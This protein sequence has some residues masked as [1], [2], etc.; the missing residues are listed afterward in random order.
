VQCQLCGFIFNQQYEQ[1]SYQV[2]YESGRSS[3]STFKTYLMQ[4]ANLLLD[5]IPDKIGT[6]V[7]V[8]AGD[9]DFARAVKSLS[10]SPQYFA[11]DPSAN[12]GPQFTG[13]TIYQKYYDDSE[14]LFPDLVI[15]RHVLE[16]QSNVHQFMQSVLHES[17][18][19]CF[20]EIPCCSF[21][22]EENFHYFSYEH[23]SYFD[24]KSLMK[25]MSAFH[26][27]PIM[28]KYM[29]TKENLITHWRRT[30]NLTKTNSPLDNEL[31][32]IDSADLRLAYNNWR[33]ELLQNICDRDS[34]LW[35][36][37]GSMSCS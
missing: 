30:R 7:E 2:E 17:P 22:L 28:S 11:Y 29:F 35:G 13:M 23:C 9:C 33:S 34:I 31:A 6:I 3:S 1:L 15:A 14:K 24:L 20:I 10:T 32:S 25:L 19:Y 12:M 21:V 16:H 18:K 5:N 37:A 8:G 4:V 27:A 26:Y 36:V